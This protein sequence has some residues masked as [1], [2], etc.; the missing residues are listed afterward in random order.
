MFK[1]LRLALR[2]LSLLIAVD[3]AV[4]MLKYGQ[5]GDS[6]AFSGIRVKVDGVT[7]EIKGEIVRLD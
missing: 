2:F 4:R 6:V 7:Y 5:K 3:V 1:A